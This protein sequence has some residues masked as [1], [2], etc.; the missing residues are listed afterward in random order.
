VS[1]SSPLMLLALL[2]V[3][4]AL[5]FALV[6]DRRRARYAVSFTNLELL[7]GVAEEKRSWRR[8]LPLALLLVALSCAATALAEPT[9]M[10][11]T[12]RQ[13]GTV[14][15]LVDDSGSMNATDV[16]P[17]RL[18]AA[19]NAMRAFLT[20]IP[21]GFKVGLVSFSSQAEVLAAPTRDR[22][23]VTDALSYLTPEDS[24]ALGDGLATAVTVAVRSLARDHVRRTPGQFLPAVIVLESDGAQNSGV[25]RP[26]RAARMAKAAGIRVDAVALGQ[27]Q[28]TLFLR[29]GAYTNVVDVPPDPATIHMIA[30][31][32]GGSAY[33]AQSASRIID[34]YKTLGSHIGSATTRRPITS[35]FSAAAA[36]LLLGAVGAGRLSEAKLP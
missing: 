25:L 16:E 19:V 17:T 15:F 30:R 6:V 21:S 3:P 24:T 23:L 12:A 4:A 28:G 34:V 22:R 13:E 32:T 31:I 29:M 9:A 14:V 20:R 10:L 2:V 18:V 8:W 1:F 35:W 7:A 5:L 11:P 26:L 27:P 36:V 33:S